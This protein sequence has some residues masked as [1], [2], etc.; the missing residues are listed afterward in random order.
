[1]VLSKPDA[2]R[3]RFLMVNRPHKRQTIIRAIY[4]HADFKY[5]WPLELLCVARH[6]IVYEAIPRFVAAPN[7][8]RNQRLGWP[9][10]FLQFAMDC[11]RYRTRQVIGRGFKF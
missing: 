8:L 7:T 10:N 2:V 11:F 5:V 4:F 6:D 9:K 1:M 3:K